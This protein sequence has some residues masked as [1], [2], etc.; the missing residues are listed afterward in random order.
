MRGVPFTVC[1]PAPTVEALVA[2]GGHGRGP[3]PDVERGGWPRVQVVDRRDEPPGA[4]LLTEELADAL[5][6]R[7]RARGVRAQPARPLPPPCL[8]ACRHLSA[9]GPQADERP[10]CAPSAARP[11]CSVLRARA[12]T[13]VREELAALVPGARVVDVDAATAE[14]PDADILVGTEAVLHRA[15]VRR[16][17][18]RLVAYLDLDQELL[19]PRYRAA[20]AGA[21]ARDPRRAAARGR[22]RARDACCC[23]RPACPTTW[24][25]RRSC[26]AEPALVAAA[27]RETA[28]TL[29]YPP[30]GALA[31]LSGD[32]DALAAAVDALVR[33]SSAVQVF[34]PTDGRALVHAADWDALADALA[35]RGRAPAARSAASAPSSTRPRV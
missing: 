31:E 30:F 9:L 23:S 7:R 3:P 28:R 6:T 11:S 32:D 29:G 14:V 33:A 24:S 8:R 20:R 16:R 22:A 18:P 34:G 4:G 35:A 2:A 10:R 27:E 19:A 12:S 21:L 25:C 17:R 13:R 15:R 26:A 5:R 1:S